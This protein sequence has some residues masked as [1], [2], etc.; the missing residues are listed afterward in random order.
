MKEPTTEKQR[1]WADLLK[2]AED[3]GLSLVEFAKTKDIP[4]QRLYQWRSTLREQSRLK[5]A[6]TSANFAQVI[7]KPFS[8]GAM[9]IDLGGIQLRFERL[10]D[11]QWLDT[12]LRLQGNTQ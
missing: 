9:S 1:Y 7:S 2:S 8:G 4:A 11:V 10:P 3:S 5:H 12:L 6:P